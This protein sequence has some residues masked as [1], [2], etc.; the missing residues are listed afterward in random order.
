[1]ATTKT[2]KQEIKRFR[3]RKGVGSHYEPNPNFDSSLPEEPGNL[4]EIQY[5]PGDVV[6]STR[7]LD[8]IFLNKFTPYDRMA[9][10]IQDEED[11]DQAAD[12]ANEAGKEATLKAAKESE[13]F[14]KKAKEE[15]I[16]VKEKG[17][18]DDYDEEEN[19]EDDN[20]VAAKADDDDE[21][22]DDEDDSEDVTSNFP[23]A[24]EAELSVRK[25]GANYFVYEK[26]E[27]E[28][29]KG[30]RKGFTKK[31]DVNKFVAS[32]ITDA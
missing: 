9:R 30:S 19:L 31:A 4:R 8:K 17:H 28:P 3:L 23:K 18:G 1:M 24:S 26:G 16:K 6:K 29:M 20:D 13:E 15:G 2:K 7:Q 27:D 32:Q 21:D 5:E 11:A 25:K 12:K 10:D 22:E 14:A